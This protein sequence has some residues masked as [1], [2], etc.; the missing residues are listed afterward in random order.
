MVSRHNNRYEN[1]IF[2][3][4]DV[5]KDGCKKLIYAIYEWKISQDKISE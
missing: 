1:E 2:V 4:S 5:T 3:I